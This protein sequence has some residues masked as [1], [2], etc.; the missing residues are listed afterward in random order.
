[1][2]LEPF[3][4]LE[5][6]EL[7]LEPEL[8]LLELVLEL[9]EEAPLEPLLEELE[10][11]VLPGPPDVEAPDVPSLMSAACCSISSWT[12]SPSAVTPNI[13]PPPRT[14]RISAYSTADAPRQSFKSRYFPIQQR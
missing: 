14:A 4:E 5:P 9:P 3:P 6:L 8:E 2:P 1:M 10:L 7:V 11:L 12:A 13:M